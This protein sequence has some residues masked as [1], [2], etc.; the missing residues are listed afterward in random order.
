M[1]EPTALATKPRFMREEPRPAITPSQEAAIPRWIAEGPAALANFRSAAFSA[2]KRTGL[3]HTGSEDFSFIR[4]GE[5]LP[6]LGPP[7]EAASGAGPTAE[8]SEE[9]AAKAR[10]R[11]EAALPGAEAIERQLVAEAA[12]SY[13]VLVDGNYL[14]G[15]SK[16]GSDFRIATLSQTGPVVT[17]PV[18]EA[19]LRIASEE[20]DAVAALGMIFAR[21]PLVIETAAKTA[22][23]K[24]LLLLH[25]HTGSGVRS[26]AVILYHGG[27]LSEASLLVR[28]ASLADGSTPPGAVATGSMENVHTVVL[29][30]PGASL[31]FLEAG[32]SAGPGASSGAGDSSLIRDIHFRKLTARLDRGSR[33]LAVS[34]HT[35]SRL[36]RNSFSVDLAGE[37]AEAEVNGATVLTGSRQSHNF[38]RIRHLVPHCVSRQHF[39]S[40]AADQ[41][42]SSVDGTIYVAEHAQQTNAY[43][44]INNL[45]LSDE[46]R[47]DSKPQLRI[48]ADD[49]KCSH[50][51]TSG[52]LDPAQQFYLESRGLPP[53]Q[54]RALMTVA[55]IAEIL[56]KAG[57]AG[58]AASVRPESAG[59]DARESF[60]AILDHALLDTLKQRLPASQGGRHA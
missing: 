27:T 16:P 12:Q 60:R 32:A 11:S 17:A 23:E 6:H 8:A 40:V 29:L 50:G 38:V 58:M 49:V 18:R 7:A 2:L 33:L 45:M 41:T 25:F 55:F 4:V 51:A 22:P 19:L 5:F 34:A 3:P 57:K 30:D 10:A 15:L 37:G 46:A 13:L 14:P 47:A 42:R 53:A 35:G 52:K 1:S 54:A 44:L 20:T 56:E 59:A 36:T 39:K 31:K 9:A 48:H 21:D 43:Q 28:H 26:D 24:P